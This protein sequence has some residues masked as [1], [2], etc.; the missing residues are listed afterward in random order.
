MTQWTYNRLYTN[1]KSPPGQ[2]KW[3][4]LSLALIV[5]LLLP[6]GCVSVNHSPVIDKLTAMSSGVV[7]ARSTSIECVAHDI[8]EDKLSYLWTTTGGN[9]SGQGSTVAW[10][11]PEI[12][13][14][15]TIVVTVRDG[16]GGETSKQL[17][18]PVIKP[19]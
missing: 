3:R 7:Q 19:G 10:A 15:Y 9:I 12:C 2:T 14:N 11:A 13:G 5:C 16:A 4:F 1:M 17:T 6:S 8:D 18:I